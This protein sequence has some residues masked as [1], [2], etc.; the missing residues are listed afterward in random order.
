MN[1]VDHSFDSFAS[2]YNFMA[3]LN[4]NYGDFF[5][6]NMSDIKGA[7]L[8]IGCGSGML[9]FKLAQYY[10]TAVGID[11]SEEMLAI[12]QEKRTAPNIK[13]ILMDANNLSLDRKFDFIVSSGTFH[14]LDDLPA[15][16][17]MIKQLLNPNGR[18][19]ILDI[20][21]KVETPATIGYI[22][23][24][25]RDFLPDMFEH[26][27]SPA[28]RLFRFRTS[29]PWLR[30]LAFIDFFRNSSSGQSTVTLFLAVHSQGK[31]SLWL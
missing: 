27:V 20:V 28:F 15:I 17:E 24:A 13:Y 29:R 10:E 31:A 21:S 30:H 3:S 2:E 14:H 9:T 12:A 25:I 16:F 6:S 5:I 22:I 23:G 8:D 7:I 18:V 11:V 19:I 26:G 1:I 4:P